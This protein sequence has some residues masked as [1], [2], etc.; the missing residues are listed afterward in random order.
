MITI[1]SALTRSKAA[2]LT[3]SVDGQYLTF[4]RQGQAVEAGRTL[5]SDCFVSEHA[6]DSI[7]KGGPI[8]PRHPLQ[9][10]AD[11]IARQFRE[12]ANDTRDDIAEQD[13][14]EAEAVREAIKDHLAIKQEV[15]AYN[16]ALN[17]AERVPTADDYNELLNIIGIA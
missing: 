10:S 9:I 11:W 4:H 6:V 1:L 17:T 13:A 7:C 3:I 14:A 15:K 12:R 8:D 16:E 2:G 5:I